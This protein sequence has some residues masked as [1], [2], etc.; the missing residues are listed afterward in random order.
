[1]R[2]E[3]ALLLIAVALVGGFFVGRKFPY[4]SFVP[5]PA[6]FAMDTANGKVCSPIGERKIPSKGV[7]G[8]EGGPDIT[9]PECGKK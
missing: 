2:K 1:M 5:A 7:T 3:I 9:I 8:V 6:G 4:H